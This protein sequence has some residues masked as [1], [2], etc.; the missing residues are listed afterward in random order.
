MVRSSL[1]VLLAPLCAVLSMGCTGDIEGDD[2]TSAGAGASGASGAQGGSG[3]GTPAGVGGAGAAGGSG[4]TG[5]GASGGSGGQPPVDPC[6]DAL[7]CEKFEDYAGV[8]SISDDQEFGPW[9]AALATP[10][11]EM[12][13]DGAHTTSGTQALHVRIDGGVEAGGRL[14]AGGDLPVLA[15]NPTHVYGSMMMY[16]DPNGTSV[17]W[18]FFGVNGDAEPSSPVTGRNAS[19]IMSSLPRE[20]VNTYSFVYGLQAEGA[21]PYHDCW[22]QSETRMPTAGWQ[23]V[24]FEMDSVARKLRMRTGDSP[25]DIA[26]VDDHGQGCVGDVPGDSAWYGPAISQMF[27]GAWSFHPM[28]G[29]LE[30]WIDDLVLDTKPVSCPAR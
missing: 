7:F 20:G 24:E 26:E 29:P 8:T 2:G 5:A 13:L 6:A 28:N 1:A 23:C 30:V 19:Y 22:F 21:D 25:T 14:F 12:E 27:V 16:I 4:A 18:T 10:G 11:A 15:G 9:R 3:S 17:H